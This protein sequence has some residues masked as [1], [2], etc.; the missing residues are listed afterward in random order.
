MRFKNLLVSGCSFT[1][2]GIGG[3]PPTNNLPGGCS[4]IDDDAYVAAQPKSWASFLAK[5][6][7]VTSMMN[8]ATSN[9]GNILIANSILECIN[10]FSYNPEE[11]LVVVGLTEPWRLDLPCSYEHPDADCGYIPWDQ[12]LI[13]YSYLDRR[14]KLVIQFEKNIEFTQIEYFTSNAVE[15]LFNFLENKK[16]AFYFLIMNNCQQTRLQ[17]VID[18]F[19]N[20]FIKLS[21]GSSMLEYCQL[22][23]SQI[24]KDDYHPNFEAHKK[25]ADQVYDYIVK[26]EIHMS[27]L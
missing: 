4:F 26:N 23:N 14:K 25:I 5:K 10:R 12:T 13:P 18:K 6:L 7:K 11:T 24:S 22:T 3:S 19:Q 8:T 21:P 20:H 27:V 9:H 2:D 17:S 16:I 15:F 1:Q